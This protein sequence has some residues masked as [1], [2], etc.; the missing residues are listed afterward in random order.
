[1]P[2]DLPEP[3]IE[4]GEALQRFFTDLLDGTNM[5]QYATERD[6]YIGNTLGPD[7]DAARV[8]REGTLEQIENNI[9]LIRGSGHA[10]PICVVF[11]PF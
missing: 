2:N 9:R 5:Q 1:M 6:A 7:T 11:P 8:L 10:W 3:S 4:I